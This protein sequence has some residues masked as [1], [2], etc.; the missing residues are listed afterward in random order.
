[1]SGLRTDMMARNM[2]P[3]V[4]PVEE[5]VWLNASRVFT[6]FR[7]FTFYL[8]IR[9]EALESLGFL[10]IMPGPS[11]VLTIDG[12]EYTFRGSGSLNNRQKVDN[13]ISEDAIYQVAAQ[14]LADIAGA[15]AVSLKLKGVAKT[16]ENALSEENIERFDEF[17]STYIES[18]DEKG[19]FWKR[20]F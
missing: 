3:A 4:E 11:L 13:L 7:N 15:R 8:E 9:Y 20:W 6:D 10:D 1:M 14:D 2:L 12:A 19:F 16:Y 18:G 17:V 5:L